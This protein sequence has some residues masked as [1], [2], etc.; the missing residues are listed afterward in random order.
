[1][2]DVCCIVLYSFVPVVNCA[3]YGL[4]ASLAPELL[5]RFSVC[6]IVASVVSVVS[7]RSSSSV[8]R[9]GGAVGETSDIVV[10]GGVLA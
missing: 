9:D 4:I 6:K 3:L 7:V 5:T 1:M 2:A 8:V 10:Y